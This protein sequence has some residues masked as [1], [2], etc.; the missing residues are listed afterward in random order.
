MLHIFLRQRARIELFVEMVPELK[1]DKLT[2]ADWNDLVDIMQ[3]LRRNHMRR[4]MGSQ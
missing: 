3:L 2:E 4:K 1:E